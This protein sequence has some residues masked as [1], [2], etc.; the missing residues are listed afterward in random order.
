MECPKEINWTLFV[1][2]RAQRLDMVIKYM[3][4]FLSFLASADLSHG[5]AYGHVNG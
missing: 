1:N 5:V 3:T 2:F 4:Q